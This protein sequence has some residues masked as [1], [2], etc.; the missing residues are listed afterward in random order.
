MRGTTVILVGVALA[1]GCGSSGNDDGRARTGQFVDSQV[2][3]VSYA[4]GNL[5]GETDAL[6][7]FQYASGAAVELSIGDIVLGSAQGAPLVTPLD[8]A[9][10]A[11]DESHPTVTNLARFLLTLDADGDPA[12]GIRISAAVRAAAAGQSVDFEQAIAEFDSDPD[13]DAVLTA[14]G[15]GPLVDVAVA[16]AHLASTLLGLIAGQ[17]SGTY[18]GDDSGSW[19]CFVDRAG[20]LL[21]CGTSADP[22][23]GSS[24]SRAPCRATGRPSSGTW[25]PAPRSAA[26]WRTAS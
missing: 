11:T 19:I 2:E 22:R 9:A 20:A 13:V 7:R 14:L 16:Q 17:Y 3:G 15:R 4:S 18:A 23:R 21:G 25:T 24:S 1:A 5:S 8:L 26:R 6:G 10:G 12:N